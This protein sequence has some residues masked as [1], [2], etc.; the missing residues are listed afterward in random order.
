MQHDGRAMT[1]VRE[2]TLSIAIAKCSFAITTMWR[3]PVPART[4]LHERTLG[5]DGRLREGLKD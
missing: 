5:S 1:I 4:S 3:D 2:I